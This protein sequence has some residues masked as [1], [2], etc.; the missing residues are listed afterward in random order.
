MAKKKSRKPLVARSR[1]V[2]EAIALQPLIDSVQDSIDRFQVLYEEGGDVGAAL[3]DL[4]ICVG[5][6]EDGVEKCE[7]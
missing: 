6:L 3:V 7:P 1:A 4:H 5:D 2:R